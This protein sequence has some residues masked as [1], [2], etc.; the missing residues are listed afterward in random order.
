MADYS[1]ILFRRILSSFLVL[2]L[3]GAMSTQSWGADSLNVR[4]SWKLKS[5][6]AP[7]YVA[8]EKGYF[9][10]EGLAVKLGEGAGAQAA[11][12]SLVQGRED[13]VVLPGIYAINAIRKGM[14]LKLIAIYH[15]VTPMAFASRPENPVRV[16]KDLINKTIAASV[17]DTTTEF[18]KVLCNRNGLNCS[19]LRLVNTDSMSRLPLVISGK[20]DVAGI[21]Y[22][23]DLPMLEARHTEVVTMDLAKYGLAVPGLALVTSDQ[24]NATKADALRHFLKALDKAMTESRRDPTEAAELFLKN[25]AGG[26]DKSVV[27]KQIRITMEYVPQSTNHPAGWIDPN[28]IKTALGILQSGD[29]IQNMQPLAHYYTND[30]FSTAK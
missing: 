19:A 7:F 11:L 3:I 16:P 22:N 28:V 9:I 4:F 8:K 18:L 5:E 29:Q 24:A 14:P 1:V 23:W 15:P 13:V 12:G 6:Y 2:S 10:D 25:W 27:A 17:G 30:L 20:A 26:L 21:Y